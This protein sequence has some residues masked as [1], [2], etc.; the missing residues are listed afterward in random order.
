MGIGVSRSKISSGSGAA[1]VVIDSERTSKQTKSVVGSVR[2]RCPNDPGM[3]PVPPIIGSN[4][5]RRLSASKSA[6][7]QPSSKCEAETRVRCGQIPERFQRN[8]RAAK[9]RNT[10]HV[11]TCCGNPDRTQR[12]RACGHATLREQFL[13]LDEIRYPRQPLLWLIGWTPG[14]FG[15]GEFGGV[16]GGVR[17]R[18]PNPDETGEIG[19]EIGS[20]CRSSSAPKTGRPAAGPLSASTNASPTHPGG[21]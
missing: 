11:L 21:T 17:G 4:F 2:D 8:I 18:S 19:G 12:G 15:G 16:R 10:K 7:H 1:S 5:S 13:V 9:F 14:E 20:P 6:I 3:T